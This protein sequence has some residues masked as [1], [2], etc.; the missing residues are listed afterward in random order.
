MSKSHFKPNNP[1]NNVDKIIEEVCNPKYLEGSETHRD[2][3]ARIAS[4]LA[5]DTDHFD[6]ILPILRGQFFLPAGRIQSSVGAARQ[7]T[8]FN[9]FVSPT[10]EDSRIG[11]F[12]ALG[13]A[14]ETM[15][16]GGE[17]ALTSQPSVL[18]VL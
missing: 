7:T 1:T 18:R 12:D 10:I 14:A 6:A 3:M 9:C 13:K 4:A 17:T 5:D 11:I 8:A 15:G 2:A 16:L